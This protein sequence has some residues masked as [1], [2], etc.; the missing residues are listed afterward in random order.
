M[1]KIF[2]ILLRLGGL[3]PELTGISDQNAV[4]YHESS[5][6]ELVIFKGFRIN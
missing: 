2:N 1:N 4:I 6:K 5:P 3:Y